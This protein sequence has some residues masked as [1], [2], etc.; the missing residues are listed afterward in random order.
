MFSKI[1]FESTH[2]RHL[3]ASRG[4][5]PYLLSPPPDGRSSLDSCP[6]LTIHAYDSFLFPFIE[7]PWKNCL[8][9]LPCFL[10]PLFLSIVFRIKLDCQAW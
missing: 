7:S 5:S 9:K 3:G 6:S 10:S 8:P 2:T 4:D 1:V